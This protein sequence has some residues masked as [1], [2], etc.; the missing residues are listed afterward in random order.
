MLFYNYTIPCTIQC[1][2]LSD[3]NKIIMNF[4]RGLKDVT[5]AKY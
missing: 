4:R 5:L 2:L 1:S 3:Q